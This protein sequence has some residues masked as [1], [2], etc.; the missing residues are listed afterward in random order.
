MNRVAL[1]VSVLLVDVGRAVV[2]REYMVY[3]LFFCVF[4]VI[5]FSRVVIFFLLGYFLNF[6]N[7]VFFFIV[8]LRGSLF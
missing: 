8:L 3:V 1:L 5:F 6:F 2:S 4:F 7:V